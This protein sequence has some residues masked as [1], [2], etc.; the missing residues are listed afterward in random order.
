MKKIIDRTLNGAIV[1][2]L[3]CMAVV[4][5]W[6]VFTRYVLGNPSK[7]T[8]EFLRYSLIWLTMLGSPYAYGLN[9]HLSINFFTKTFS[10]KHQKIINTFIELAVIFLSVFVLIYGGILVCMNSVGQTS[11]AMH[12][13][14]PVLYMSLPISGVLTIYYSV[15]KL[16]A[17]F[18]SEKVYEKNVK[19]T[20][21]ETVTEG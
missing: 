16:K 14:M 7:V 13:P 21:K 10:A 12:L 15:L 19:N 8:E 6:Q 1:I 18:S 5:C 20:L 4:C 9:K 3:A 11:A 17:L 2:L